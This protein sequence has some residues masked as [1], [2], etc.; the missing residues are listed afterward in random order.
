MGRTASDS[1]LE[2][3]KPLFPEN[4]LPEFRKQAE[5]IGKGLNFPLW[6]HEKALLIQRYLQLFTF[7]AKHGVY[8]DGFA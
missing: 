4:A 2:N 6:S 1:R 5:K 3:E 7:V 8:I